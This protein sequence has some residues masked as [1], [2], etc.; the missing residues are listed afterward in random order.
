VKEKD[1][2]RRKIVPWLKEHGIYYFKPPG[3]P[4]CSHK[5]IPDFILC[6]K[7]RFIGLEAKSDR[8]KMSEWQ[9]KE[10][11]RV[12]RAGGLFYLTF[13]KNWESVKRLLKAML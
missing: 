9:E 4:Y 1:F 3:G 13:P 12:E 7:G 10:R 6:V 2:C 5:G 8:G 11:K